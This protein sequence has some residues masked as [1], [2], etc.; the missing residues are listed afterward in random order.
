MSDFSSQKAIAMEKRHILE[1]EKRLAR[2]E[3][4][5]KELIDRGQDHLTG[6]AGEVLGLLR[7][8]LELSRERLRYL[9]TQYGDASESS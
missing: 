5:M 7:D 4:L 3:A 1:G 6:R 9:Q 8:S 2:Q